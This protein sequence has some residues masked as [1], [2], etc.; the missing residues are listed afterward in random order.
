[1]FHLIFSIPSWYVIARF[2]FPLA[3]PLVLKIILSMVVLL[4]SQYLLISRF[5][6]GGI[7]S[8]EMPRAVP[9]LISWA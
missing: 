7:F 3:M 1:M 8:P 5:T 9:I 4:A 2:V 6:P